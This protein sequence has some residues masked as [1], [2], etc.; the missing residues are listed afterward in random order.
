[1]EKLARTLDQ[2]FVSSLA[3][4]CHTGLS[5]KVFCGVRPFAGQ[6]STLAVRQDLVQPNRFKFRPSAM[7]QARFWFPCNSG[8]VM[9]RSPR[10]GQIPLAWPFVRLRLP[11]GHSQT[12]VP[13][14]SS[15]KSIEKA[16]IQRNQ[17]LPKVFLWSVFSELPEYR[18]FC[19]QPLI[20]AR[21]DV[22]QESSRRSLGRAF[23]NRART[24]QSH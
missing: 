18:A 24:P 5:H 19:W 8:R 6:L 23:G 16:E 14:G 7:R 12:V 3:F 10:P 13:N 11:S 20:A 22:L 17:R 4:C 15:C 2:S 1:M 21:G 9:A